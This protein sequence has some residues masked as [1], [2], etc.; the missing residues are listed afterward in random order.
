MIAEDWVLPG[1]V[2]NVGMVMSTSMM[3]N[4]ICI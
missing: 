2:I 1:M 4:V 3:M